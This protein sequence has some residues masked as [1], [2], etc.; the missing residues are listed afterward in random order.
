VHSRFR[1]EGAF[2]YFNRLPSCSLPS[3]S[4]TPHRS[5]RA[6]LAYDFWLPMNRRNEFHLYIRIRQIPLSSVRLSFERP[7]LFIVRCHMFFLQ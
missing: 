3:Q 2:S 4:S 5:A 1:A 6:F 7:R